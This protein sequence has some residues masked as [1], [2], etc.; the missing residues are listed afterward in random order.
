M[1]FGLHGDTTQYEGGWSYFMRR[2][3]SYCN[4]YSS[5]LDSGTS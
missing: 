4:E 3:V 5:P 2:L 1:D